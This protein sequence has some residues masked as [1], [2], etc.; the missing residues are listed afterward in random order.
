MLGC[1][2]RAPGDSRA[3]F[4]LITLILYTAPKQRDPAFLLG[5][6]MDDISNLNS[7]DSGLDIC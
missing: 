4:C 6:Y 7:T 1:D 2:C 5:L 3:L